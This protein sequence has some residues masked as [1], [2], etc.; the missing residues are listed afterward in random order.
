MIIAMENTN[1]ILISI[2]RKI[3]KI[4]LCGTLEIPNLE[5]VDPLYIKI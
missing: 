2:L 3:S 5:V 4:F 1:K